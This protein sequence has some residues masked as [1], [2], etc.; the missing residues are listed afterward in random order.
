MNVSRNFL[1]QTFGGKTGPP[2]F[3]AAIESPGLDVPLRCGRQVPATKK[4][5]A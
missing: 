2:S 4:R 5:D 3:P 1:S